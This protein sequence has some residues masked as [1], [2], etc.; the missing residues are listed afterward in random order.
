M[1]PQRKHGGSRKSEQH[2]SHPRPKPSPVQGAV[3]SAHQN[4]DSTAT[5][6]HARTDH[7][8]SPTPPLRRISHH[9]V[10]VNVVLFCCL[11]FVEFVTCLDLQ[12]AGLCSTKVDMMMM[13]IMTQSSSSYQHQHLILQKQ[14]YQWAAK[15]LKG[16][17]FHCMVL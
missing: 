6:E 9:T 5:S 11:F 1:K 15:C 12:L 17:I 3:R 7:Q 4:S 2:P 16:I 14:G 10:L 8:P 13:M